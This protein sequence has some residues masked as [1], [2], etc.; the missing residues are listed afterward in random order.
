MHRPFPYIFA[1]KKR[2]DYEA[3]TLF[4]R[5]FYVVL[6]LVKKSL[7]RISP[8]FRNFLNGHLPCLDASVVDFCH[9]LTLRD[10]FRKFNDCVFKVGYPVCKSYAVKRLDNRVFI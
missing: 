2:P 3:K 5:N 7:N 1:I 6:V 8:S 9:L 10:D 4:L